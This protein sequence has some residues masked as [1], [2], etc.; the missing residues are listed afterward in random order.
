LARVV[1][2]ED[3]EPRFVCSDLVRE[4]A[5]ELLAAS[6]EYDAT[7]ARLAEY[8]IA[9][10]ELFS[11]HDSSPRMAAL[12]AGLIRESS[13]FDA[14]LGWALDPARVEIGLRLAV[15]LREPWWFAGT[16]SEGSA[17][18]RA[19]LEV[20]E[21]RASMMNH[22]LLADAFAAGGR[23]AEARGD[24]PAARMLL[25]KALPLKRAIG[26]L[27]GVATLLTN[28]GAVLCECGD[29]PQARV[30]F[31]EGLTIRRTLGDNAAIGRSL[32]YLGINAADEGDAVAAT[33]HLEDALRHA[34]AVAPN[35]L[36]I[37]V[38]LAVLGTVAA[39]NGRPDQAET[40][41]TE[42]L[43]IGRLLGNQPL[44]ASSTGTL[45]W[46]A[47][48]RGAYADAESLFRQA[49]DLCVAMDDWVAMPDV[50]DG[51]AASAHARLDS[52]AAARLVGQADAMRRRRGKE[53]VPALRD[54]RDLFI[55]AVRD[56]IGADAFSAEW[57]V[58]NSRRTRTP[59]DS[60]VR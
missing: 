53:V 25:A 52:R 48:Q 56:A 27:P 55:A 11:P 29:Y 32:V 14:V 34:R 40:W 44:V 57:N 58:G 30:L 1:D 10:A 35:E 60:G 37:G 7:F 15:A 38:I 17:W 43:R 59:A 36:G 20:A 3:T 39:R 51:L 5:A 18:L 2:E 50:T 46:V 21:A 16:L 31:E 12:L 8:L 45:A 28:M 33:A 41:G 19:L 23:L 6:G 47:F 22:E 24:L 42:S 13:N 54:R 9:R 26:D 4:Y 49:L